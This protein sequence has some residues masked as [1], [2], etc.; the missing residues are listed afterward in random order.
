MKCTWIVRLKSG[1]IKLIAIA[2]LVLM[3]AVDNDKSMM[4]AAIHS[5]YG[6]SSKTLKGFHIWLVGE[7]ICWSLPAVLFMVFQCIR[8]C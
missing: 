2:S 5:E 4:V 8:L 3:V 6:E 1:F 7:N